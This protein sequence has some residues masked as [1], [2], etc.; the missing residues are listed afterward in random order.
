MAEIIGADLRE[1]IGKRLKASPDSSWDEIVFSLAEE[2][3]E[4]EADES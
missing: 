3:Y 2:A 1:A 4:E